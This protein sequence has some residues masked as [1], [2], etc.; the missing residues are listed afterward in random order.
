MSDELNQDIEGKEDTLLTDGSTDEGKT[1]EQKALEATAESQKVE[2][3]ANKA[4]DSKADEDKGK[5]PKDYEDFKLPEG[6]ELDEVALADFVPMAKEAGLT[7]EQAQK[8]VD[9]QA[10]RVQEYSDSQEKAWT[11]MQESWRVATKSD[12][13]IGGPAFDQSL[14][15]AKTFLKAYGTPE[16]ME[17]LDTTG[18]GNHPEVI[19]AFARAGKAM[20]DDKLAIGGPGDGKKLAED[21]MFPNQSSI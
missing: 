6:V 7:Q 16:L 21:I 17:A 20:G 19:R 14:A 10:K 11:D 5:S 18:M 9:F 1:E 2:A 13:E 8:L 3:E 12:K 15:Q 4:E